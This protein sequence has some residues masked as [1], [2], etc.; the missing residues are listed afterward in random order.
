ML[1]ERGVHNFKTKANF[2]A[3]L[4]KC[5]IFFLTTDTYVYRKDYQRENER[6]IKKVEK[7]ERRKEKQVMKKIVLKL[8]KKYPEANCND[9]FQLLPPRFR[10]VIL[11]VSDLVEFL[12]RRNLF[13]NTASP[14]K[15][16]TNQEMAT[17]TGISDSCENFKN[18][19]PIDIICDNESVLDI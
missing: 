3:F 6:I 1:N 19:S 15:T 16:Q 11:S 9:L 18:T 10:S 12:E 8:M 14:I 4:E 5:S 7:N 2:V 13:S 17:E